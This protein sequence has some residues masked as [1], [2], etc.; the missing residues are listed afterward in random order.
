MKHPLLK[1]KVIN[2]TNLLEFMKKRYKYCRDNNGQNNIYRKMRAK[3]YVEKFEEKLN[4]IQNND[5]RKFQA[6]IEQGIELCIIDTSSLKYFKEQTAKK[7][8][9]IICDIINNLVT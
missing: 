6:C 3:F 9:D 4:Q 8:L 5:S 7:Y 2:A 1:D